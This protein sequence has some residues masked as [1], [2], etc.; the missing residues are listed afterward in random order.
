MGSAERQPC[1]IGLLAM[2]KGTI[3]RPTNRCQNCGSPCYDGDRFC[4]LECDKGAVDDLNAF[5]RRGCKDEVM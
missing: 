3:P 1:T 5:V 4:S 2:D